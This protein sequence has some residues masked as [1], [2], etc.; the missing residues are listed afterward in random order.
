ML[1]VRLM[2]W[3]NMDFIEETI[4]GILIQK[5]N[6]RVEVVIGD[7]GSTDGTLEYLQEQQ[8]LRPDLFRILDRPEGGKYRVDRLKNGRIHNF[9]DIVNHCEGKY[10]AIL[11]G[12]DYWT[13]PQKLQT[14]VD[15]LETNPDFSFSCHQS[16]ELF[17]NGDLILT[18]E[19][20]PSEYDAAYL[21][22]KGWHIR[23][24]AVVF[25]RTDLP[26]LPSWIYTIESMDFTV[27][28]LLTQHGQK[29][30]MFKK[31]MA[32]Y[33]IHGK[34][35]SAK[36]NNNYLKI[37]RRNVY[38]F[39]RIKSFQTNPEYI[40]LLDKRIVD[41]RTQLFYELRNRKSE[42]IKTYLEVISLA[43]KLGKHN[44]VLSL[45]KRKLD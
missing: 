9:V 6:F 45:F 21:F 26:P 41:S 2:V 30:K 35:V 44:N 27:Q 33:R 7:D 20:E 23:S 11:D 29:I 12:D 43:F 42:G 36:L 19:E 31:S 28:S 16:H 14:Q 39:S 22:K 24:V 25:R 13:D 37:L 15:F 18:N 3:N 5:T 32:V 4:K 40:A 17:D 38:L 8:R 34:T 10:I 1:S